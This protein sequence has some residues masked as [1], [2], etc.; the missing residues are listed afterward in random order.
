MSRISSWVR[1]S[2]STSACRKWLSRSSRA[3]AAALVDAPARSTRRSS[4]RS[5][6]WYASVSGW[7]NSWPTTWSGRMAPSFI[8]RNARQVVHRQAE[9]R[10]EDLRRERRRELR[11]E[12]DLRRRR[13]SRR[14]GRSPAGVVDSS[15]T[16]IRCGANS[17][18][19]SL[20]YFR[21]SGGSICSGISGRFVFRSWAVVLDENDVGVA[22]H[23]VDAGPGASRSRRRRRGGTPGV[24]AWSIE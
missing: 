3:L 22:E 14:S 12:V 9:Q 5:A 18:S 17:G 15:S 23:L 2:P 4:R 1:R 16:F 21:W 10:Q 7:P 20:R 11:G 6:C 8:F 13:R 19:R 24:L